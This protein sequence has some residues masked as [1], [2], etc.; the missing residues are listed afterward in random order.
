MDGIISFIES[1]GD[2]L[3]SGFD[4]LI[5]VVND[6][7]YVAKLLSTV[8]SSVPLYFTWIPGEMIYFI[9]AILAIAIIYKIIG[10]EG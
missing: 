3:S 2:L 4:Y 5:S 7:V 9:E 6:L 10:R 1:I 8:V